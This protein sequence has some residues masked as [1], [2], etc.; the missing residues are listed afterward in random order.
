M[1]KVQGNTIVV[2]IP[3]ESLNSM[4]FGNLGMTLAYLENTKKGGCEDNNDC[5]GRQCLK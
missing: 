3:S 5:Q 2:M 1:I 4:G